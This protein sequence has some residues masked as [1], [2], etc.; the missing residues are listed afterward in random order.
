[1]F[2]A[3]QASRRRRGRWDGKY[4]SQGPKL[5]KFWK[6]YLGRADQS[7]WAPCVVTGLRKPGAEVS[8]FVVFAGQVADPIEPT[9]LGFPKE[10]LPSELAHRTPRAPRQSQLEGSHIISKKD[11]AIKEWRP[12]GDRQHQP[13]KFSVF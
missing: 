7:C 12:M 2:L 5:G 4:V 1:M 13:Q 11:Q 6:L 10:K 3:H 8:Q 9:V